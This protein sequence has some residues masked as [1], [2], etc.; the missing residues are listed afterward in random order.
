MTRVLIVDDETMITQ[1]LETLIEMMLDYE[2]HTYND[3][4]EL[5]ASD[6]LDSTPIDLVVSDFM[7]PKKNGIEVLAAILEKQPQAVPILLTGYADKENAIKSINEVGLYYY[8]EKP[9]DNQEL[10]TVIKNGVE[11]KH[12]ED[13]VQKNMIIIQKRNDEITRLYDLLRKDFNHEMNNVVS[14][15]VALAN[16]IEAKDA[17]TDGHTRRVS[18]LC[19]ALGKRAGIEG[20]ALR[21]LEMS[22]IVH[23][24]GK[25]GT[26]DQILNKPGRLTKLEFETMMS[27]PELGAKILRPLT[28]LEGCVDPVLHHHEKL[29]GSGYPEGLKG[30]KISLHSRIVC[31]A[32]IF[33]A[34][35]TDRPYKKRFT[36]QRTLSILDRMAEQGKIDGSIVGHL[37]ELVTSKELFKYYPEENSEE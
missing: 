4:E 11:K 8:L 9:W 2:V 30:D 21:V 24:I 29:D 33:D 27:H 15:V 12:L 14:V 1:T 7:M 23:D 18:D 3:P 25:V 5:L 10:V 32:D 26:P 31:V 20:D 37:H 13:E 17:Y 34:L 22:A 35:F 19:V 6:F 28:A 36:I 16:L